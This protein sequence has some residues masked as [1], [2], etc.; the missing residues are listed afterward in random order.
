MRNRIWGTI[1][2]D[3]NCIKDIAVAERRARLQ[4]NIKLYSMTIRVARWC[5]VVH[6]SKMLGV[7]GLVA[8]DCHS[9][10]F[11]GSK[12]AYYSLG[13]VVCHP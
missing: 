3:T 6:E 11:R 9:L 8:V 12:T 10:S 4:D 1:A 5:A 2:V 13:T 7:L